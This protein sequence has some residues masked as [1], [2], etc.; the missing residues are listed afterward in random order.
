MIICSVQY[1]ALS[2]IHSKLCASL[3]DYVHHLVPPDVFAFLYTISSV[4][5]QISVVTTMPVLA[6]K[7]TSSF[8]SFCWGAVITLLFP[9]LIVPKDGFG[10]WDGSWNLFCLIFD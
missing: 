2:D 5:T 1:D 7:S 6:V 8:T 4:E 9:H 10:E 3:S